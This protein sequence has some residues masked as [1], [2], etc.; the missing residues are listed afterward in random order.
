MATPPGDEPDEEWEPTPEECQARVDARRA[1]FSLLADR[2]PADAVD[3]YTTAIF[4]G[5]A[6]ILK[7]LTKQGEL[8]SAPGMPAFKSL[9]Q[10]LAH[11]GYQLIYRRR[12]N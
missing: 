6:E 4:E 2:Y 8:L 11:T 5:F 12:I 1:V 3:L 7:L 9:N 10:Q